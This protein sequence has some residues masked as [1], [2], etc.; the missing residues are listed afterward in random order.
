[1][2]MSVFEAYARGCSRRTGG[3]GTEP[4]QQ[5]FQE[6]GQTQLGWELAGY[7]SFKQS[8]L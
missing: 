8:F 5:H 7:I 1:M 3:G 6:N 4:R 2:V